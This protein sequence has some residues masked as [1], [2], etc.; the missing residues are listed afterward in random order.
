MTF[1]IELDTQIL[2][3]GSVKDAVVREF[4]RAF[5]ADVIARSGGNISAAARLAR[6]DRSGFRRLIRQSKVPT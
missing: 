6:M 5:V 3:Y 1:T 2:S 4:Q